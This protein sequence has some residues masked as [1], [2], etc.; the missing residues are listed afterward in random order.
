MIENKVKVQI[1]QTFDEL[2]DREERKNNLIVFNMKESVKEDVNEAVKEDLHQLKEILTV[3]NP[4]MKESIIKKLSTEHIM[5]LGRR[6][7]NPDDT[8]TRPLKLLLPNESTKY[9][10]IRN[11]YKLKSCANHPKIGFKF[12]LTRQQQAD[13][14][15]L[16]QELEQRKAA[17]EDVM[18]YRGK[19]IERSQHLKL[20][21][22]HAS[23]KDENKPPVQKV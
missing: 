4:E 5:R 7:Q 3:T 9:K 14:R 20:K 16:R 22:E 1:E 6:N 11:S 19:I 2:K 17:N 10:I 12:D 13:E 21:N 23:K 18:I 8:R 15:E